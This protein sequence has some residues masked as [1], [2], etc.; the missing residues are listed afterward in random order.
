MTNHQRPEPSLRDIKDEDGSTPR[1]RHKAAVDFL[2]PKYG[3]PG[4]TEEWFPR[5]R[6]TRNEERVLARIW[7][8]QAPSEFGN[9][10]QKL[11]HMSAANAAK[12][13]GIDKSSWKKAI[14]ALT[15]KGIAVAISNGPRKPVTYKVDLEVCARLVKEDME[16][17][18][19]E[20]EDR[21]R[22]GR[23]RQQK[24]YDANIDSDDEDLRRRAMQQQRRMD[25]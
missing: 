13:V 5:L 3:G 1:E 25:E 2:K 19:R 6:L 12:S 11:F 14:K 23:E 8:F 10:E 17:R 16:R 22:I 20:R 21:V 15:D 7:G 24:W 4:R 9:A 18:E